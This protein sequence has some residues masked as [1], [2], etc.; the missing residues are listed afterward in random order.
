MRL[1]LPFGSGLDFGSAV[2]DAAVSLDLNS[3]EPL[4]DLLSD[5]ESDDFDSVDFESFD[6]ES[7][8]VD[9]DLLSDL[10]SDALFE[11]DAADFL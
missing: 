3:D 2:F 6:F 8:D 7:D 1:P 4:S 5:F 10:E 9:S 11:S